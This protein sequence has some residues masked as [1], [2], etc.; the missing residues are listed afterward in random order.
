MKQSQ[1]Q[2][3]Q[4]KFIIAAALNRLTNENLPRVL[5][6]K[7][8]VDTGDVLH[9]YDLKFLRRLLG[10]A[11]DLSAIV[12]RNPEYMELRSKALGL[13]HDIMKKSEEN[14]KS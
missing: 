5:S 14:E 13:C 4:D 11:D 7:E 2:T 10:N 3:E 9:D 6:L 8:K 1:K 12:E